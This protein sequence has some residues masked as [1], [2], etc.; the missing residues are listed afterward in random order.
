[1]FC[2]KLFSVTAEGR[3]CTD[4]LG[5]EQEGRA[6]S[7][8]RSLKQTPKKRENFRF[9][10]VKDNF[11]S[12]HIEGVHLDHL[13]GLSLIEE[14]HTLGSK[15]WNVLLPGQCFN[16][17][18]LA[19]KFIYFKYINNNNGSSNFTTTQRVGSYRNGP[20]YR[21]QNHPR[22]L[23]GESNLVTLPAVGVH[24]HT[25][26]GHLPA[27]VQPSAFSSS[28]SLKSACKSILFPQHTQFP[29]ASHP[30]HLAYSIP[31]LLSES[32]KIPTPLH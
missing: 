5:S 22:Q 27:N 25:T 23:K 8:V 14:L 19:S 6:H 32:S 26:L 7:H 2:N 16:L 3:G 18:S 11:F 20:W 1:M 24:Y 4:E 30:L 12:L 10:R 29:Y 13:K 9:Q 31:S 28:V 21:D 15:S 17:A